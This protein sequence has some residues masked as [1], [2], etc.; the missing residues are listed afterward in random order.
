[1]KSK[2]TINIK[3]SFPVISKTNY[4]YSVSQSANEFVICNKS[5]LDGIK[6]G[7]IREEIIDSAG[8]LF[9]KLKTEPVGYTNIL[10]GFDLASFS[11]TYY[12]DVYLEKLKELTVPQLIAIGL[13]V[14]KNKP[15]YYS[16]TMLDIEK[17]KEV[18]LQLNKKEDILKYIFFFVEPTNFHS[19]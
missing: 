12:A 8:N 5:Y 18:F 11:S 16:D 6:K 2:G 3:I 13:D 9:R 7:E 10:W 4:G 19:P 15:S 14:L 1:M 17:H